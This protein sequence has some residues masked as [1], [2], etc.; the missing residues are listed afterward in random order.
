[1][2]ALSPK[3]DQLQRLFRYGNRFMLLLWRLGSYGNSPAINQVMALTHHGRK[4]GR[5]YRTPLNY[6]VVAGAIYCTAGFGRHSDW[7]RNLR[8]NPQVEVWL[9]ERWWDGVAEEV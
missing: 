3:E 9:R 7:Y 4:S 6:A 1:M 5:R 8:A 2:H